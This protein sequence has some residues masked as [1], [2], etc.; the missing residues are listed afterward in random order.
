MSK[1][2]QKLSKV[3]RLK[4]DEGPVVIDTRFV[5]DSLAG[6]GVKYV[7]DKDPRG[8]VALALAAVFGPCGAVEAGLDA[9][10]VEKYF[11]LS[12]EIFERYQLIAQS[13]QPKPTVAV[14]QD[15][16]SQ[17]ADENQPSYEP[18]EEPKTY[19]EQEL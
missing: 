7:S 4:V 14:S 13:L 17:G 10:T 18:I 9:A 5:T 11:A 6:M 15:A 1:P 8:M 12:A 16:V 19:K 3:Q 2:E